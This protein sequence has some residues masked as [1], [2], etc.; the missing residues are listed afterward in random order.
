MKRL[1]ELLT[2]P[3]ATGSGLRAAEGAYAEWVGTVHTLALLQV[4]DYRGR[5]ARKSA[6]ACTPSRRCT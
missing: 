3:L 2:R 1:L 5:G 6:G 4:R